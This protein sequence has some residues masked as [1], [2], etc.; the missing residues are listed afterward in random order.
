VFE[1]F[2]KIAERTIA[3]LSTLTREGFVFRVD[4]R[5]RPTGS[6]GPLVQS[7]DAFK[8]YYASRA[9]TWERQAL[10]R[11][12][13]V[14]GDNAVG[15]LFME[16]L[17]Y[18]IYQDADKTALARDVL[19]MRRRM[20]EELGKES[21][22]HYNIKQ[23]A[24]GLVDIEFFVQY[25]QLLHGKRRPWVRVPGTYNA[26]RALKKE[27]LLEEN[28][29]RALLRAYLFMRQ[30]ESRMRIV[31]NQATSDLSRDPEKL[32]PLARRM[33]Y[34]DDGT[35]PGQKLLAEYESLSSQVR[36]IFGTLLQRP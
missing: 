33:G 23:G 2:S 6:K 26:L 20:E 29:Y 11:T 34:A 1:Y 12:R 14:A 3:Y 30:L 10:V 35:L 32:H 24:G 27:K 21:A 31:S 15:R 19:A 5:L 4:T 8:D 13:C 17:Q 16:A 9:E 28:E 25:L 7:V 18:L 36:S 22:A